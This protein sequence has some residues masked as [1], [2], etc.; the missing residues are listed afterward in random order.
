MADIHPPLTRS[1]S[2]DHAAVV[3]VAPRSCFD[4]AGDDKGNPHAGKTAGDPSNDAHAT[5]DSCSVTRTSV[6]P[7]APVP[8]RPS[9][10]ALVTRLKI[11]LARNSVVVFRFLNSGTSSRF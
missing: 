8:R 10:I 2:V 3:F 7:R 1:Q 11:S 4:I 9:W 6:I 5:W